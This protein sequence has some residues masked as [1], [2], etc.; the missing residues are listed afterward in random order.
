M[1]IILIQTVD[2]LIMIK[3]VKLRLTHKRGKS[4]NIIHMTFV[5]TT[6]IAQ[7]LNYNAA[8]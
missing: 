8:C 7:S 2:D 4:I 5:F 1:I 3:K 6:T